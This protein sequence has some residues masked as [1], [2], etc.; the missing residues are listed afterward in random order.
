MGEFLY[1]KDKQVY[2]IDNNIV[3]N[4]NL[5]PGYMRKMENS[6]Y[7]F[8]EWIKLRYSSNTNSIAR[9]L[10]GSTFGQGNRDRIETETHA[11]RLCDCY[12]IK[13]DSEDIKI[14][15]GSPYYTDFWKGEGI[16]NGKSVPTLYVTGYMDKYWV[17]SKYL[18]KLGKEALIEIECYKVC[19]ACNVRVA[20]ILKYG[21]N[22]ILVENVTNTKYMLEQAD[23]SGLMDPDNYDEN[24]IERLFKYDGIRMIVIDA[25]IG[26]GDRHLG[27]FGWLR[28]TDT[29]EYVDMSPLYDFDHALDSKLRYDRLIED[30]INICKINQNYIYEA[31]RICKTV[32]NMDTIDIFK[33]RASSLI[34]HINI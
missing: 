2:D 18:C 34:G 24:N 25:I 4:N 31:L 10:K 15:D 1:C 23:Q 11:L 22:G 6:P 16:C 26:N 17:N 8:K 14:K 20:N 28:D 9:K 7:K 30:A 5:L 32:V 3:I 19:K 12:W 29:G 21:D 27:N 33:I 13:S